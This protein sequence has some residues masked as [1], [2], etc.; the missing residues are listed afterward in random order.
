[1]SVHINDMFN[2]TKVAKVFNK[3]TNIA[4]GITLLAAV[5]VP[6]ADDFLEKKSISICN[7]DY[8]SPM[9]VS[10]AHEYLINKGLSGC[11]DLRR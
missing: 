3:A 7:D 10:N 9:A 6:L 4:A 8:A 1:M 11:P 5:A 2:A